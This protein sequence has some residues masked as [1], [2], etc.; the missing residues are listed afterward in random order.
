MLPARPV[1]AHSFVAATGAAAP[2]AVDAQ[3][4]SAHLK[5]RGL[6]I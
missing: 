5:S 4:N 1:D 6:A 3:T 2:K